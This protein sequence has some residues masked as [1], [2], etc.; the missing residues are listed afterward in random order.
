ME[1]FA[2]RS[3]RPDR[4][5]ASCRDAF[6]A[7]GAVVGLLLYHTPGSRLDKVQLADLRAPGAVFRIFAAAD[8]L[9]SVCREGLLDRAS[10][11]RRTY[12]SI[13]QSGGANPALGRGSCRVSQVD[14]AYS[15]AG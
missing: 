1:W 4:G 13:R 14:L 12:Q 11:R 5:A 2:D 9:Q 8:F 10:G 3:I 15:Q 7:C 6:D